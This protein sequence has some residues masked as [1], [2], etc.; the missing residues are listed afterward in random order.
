MRCTTRG[1]LA[2]VGGFLL[3]FMMGALYIAGNINVYVCSMLSEYGPVNINEMIIVIPTSMVFEGLFLWSGPVLLNKTGFI[4]VPVLL[5]G[6]LISGGTFLASFSHSLLQF[7]LSYPLCLGI[8]LG[9]GVLVPLIIG[10]EYFPNNKGFVSG[11]I[12]SGIGFG[13]LVFSEIAIR[14]V[15]PEDVSPSVIVEGGRIFPFDSD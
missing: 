8:A 4:W 5:A 9:V 11:V 15:N 12:Y 3:H 1:A 10:W 2:I 13:S 6:I 7:V 14:L